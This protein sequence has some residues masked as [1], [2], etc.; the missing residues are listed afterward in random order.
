M[1]ARAALISGTVLS[2]AVVS[3][4]SYTATLTIGVPPVLHLTLRDLPGDYAQLAAAPTGNGWELF[5]AVAAIYALCLLVSGLRARRKAQR[6]TPGE[7][8]VYAEDAG[9]APVSERWS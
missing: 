6:E 3:A 2:L 5:A 1:T 8:V 4:W 9:S 7:P